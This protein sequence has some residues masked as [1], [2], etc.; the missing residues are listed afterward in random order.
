MESKYWVFT[1]NNPPPNSTPE[2]FFQT[3]GHPYKYLIYQKEKGEKDTIHHQGYIVFEKKKKF[4]TL[5]KIAE[6][7][8][9]EKRKGTHDE[10][11]EYCSKTDTRV[12]GPYEFGDDSDIPR[13]KGERTD[14]IDFQKSVQAGCYDITTLADEHFTVFIHNNRAFKNYIDIKKQANAKI[15]MQEEFN[16]DFQPRQWQQQALDLLDKQEDREVLWIVDELGGSGKT[17]LAKHLIIT[18]DAFYCTNGKSQDVAFAYGNE[19]VVVF[20]YTRDYEAYVNYSIIEQF[21]NGIFF[22]SKYE[23]TNKFFKPAKV[24]VFSNFMPNQEKLS[25]D[26]WKIYKLEDK[27][28]LIKI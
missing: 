15:Q 3:T 9:W 13:K 12:E 4:Q 24:I 28:K 2:T 18:Y 26:R 8:H 10:A 17:Y 27:K 19:E 20:D 7:Y 25:S 11:K 16:K 23:S 14:I 1:E 5:K 21:K 22:S 6:R